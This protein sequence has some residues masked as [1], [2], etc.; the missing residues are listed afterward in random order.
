MGQRTGSTPCLWPIFD[1]N[2]GSISCTWLLQ[3]IA[4][5]AR[6]HYAIRYGNSISPQ[7][8]NHDMDV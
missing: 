2:T 6:I 7:V 5:E 3:A 8:E 4:M 1:V